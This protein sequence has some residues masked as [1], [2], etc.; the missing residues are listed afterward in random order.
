MKR[1]SYTLLDR[2][3]IPD[4]DTPQ[5]MRSGNLIFDSDKCRE[6]GL[7]VTICPG[8][9]LDTEKASKTDLQTGKARG[10]KYGIPAVIKT[11]R[12]ATLCIA[13][14]D[15]GAACPHGAISISTNFNPTRFYKRITQ[16]SEMRYPKHY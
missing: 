5:G 9:C 8:G 6:C 10:G 7:C 12:G 3:I 11:I 14:F 13:C 16:T 15:C 4:Y 1:E 2:L